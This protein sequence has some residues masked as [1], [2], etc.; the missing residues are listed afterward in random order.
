MGECKT[1]EALA[2]LSLELSQRLLSLE[3]S[4]STVAKGEKG[5]KEDKEAAENGW[6]TDGSD[7]IGRMAR[8][9]PD[10]SRMPQVDPRPCPLGRLSSLSLI[11]TGTG[12]SGGRCGGY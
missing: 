3:Q 4:V 12:V 8:F 6:H 1:L 7:F 5:S 2:P 10:P 9:K 11:Y